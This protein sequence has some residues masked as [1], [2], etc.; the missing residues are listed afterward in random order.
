[1]ERRVAK[2]AAAQLLAH[3]VG[4]RFEAIVTGAAP[5]GTWVRLLALPV[6]GKVVQGAAGLDVGQRTRVRLLH[7]D[8]ARGFIDFAQ[9]AGA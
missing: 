6:E 1:M 7:T 8:V 4:E 5:K 9:I 3:R 2:S